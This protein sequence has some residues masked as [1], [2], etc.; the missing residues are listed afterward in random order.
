L[1]P[2]PVPHA[3][4]WLLAD[5]GAAP[6]LARTARSRGCRG[7]WRGVRWMRPSASDAGRSEVP[8]APAGSS[9]RQAPGAEAVVGGADHRR[10]RPSRN[11]SFSTNHPEIDGAVDFGRTPALAGPDAAGRAIPRR[12]AARRGRPDEHAL[13]IASIARNARAP[14]AGMSEAER[15]VRDRRERLEARS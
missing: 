7:S 9:C 8:L 13:R 5:S 11:G 2:A 6:L 10:G 12:T 3:R 1:R 4:P 14:F 15:R